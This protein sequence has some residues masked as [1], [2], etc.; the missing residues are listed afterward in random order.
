MKQC[1]IDHDSIDLY[2]KQSNMTCHHLSIIESMVSWR[3]HPVFPAGFYPPARRSSIMP[4]KRLTWSLPSSAWSQ[5]PRTS[6]ILWGFIGFYR[7][8]PSGK[9]T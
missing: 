6:Q 7:Y 3:I 8:L 2:M 1:N 4:W 9:L 5:N